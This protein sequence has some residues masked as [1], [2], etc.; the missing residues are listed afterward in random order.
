V[1]GSQRA[2]VTDPRRHDQPDRDARRS[3]KVAATLAHYDHIR[4]DFAAA[5][6]TPEI[7]PERITLALEQFLLTQFPPTPNSI[8]HC[9]APRR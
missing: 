7:T 6:G 3:A 9:A 5:F 8:V 2:C 1:D 4:E